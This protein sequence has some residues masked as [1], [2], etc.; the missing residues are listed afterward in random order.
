MHERHGVAL[1][2]GLADDVLSEKTVAAGVR[3]LNDR[4]GK[5][6]NLNSRYH[7]R[8]AFDYTEAHEKK[9]RSDK[10]LAA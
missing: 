8:R 3:P 7:R 1:Q 2:P 6:R 5:N 4:S 9:S 10:D